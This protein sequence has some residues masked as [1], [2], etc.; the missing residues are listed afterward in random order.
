MA[1]REGK[2]WCATREVCL[3]GHGRHP[4][5]T[6]SSPGNGQGGSRPAPITG[7]AAAPG[8]ASEKRTRG[9]RRGKDGSTR[10]QGLV[11]N[12]GSL[13]RRPRAAPGGPRTNPRGMAS[14]GA[15]GF[16]VPLRSGNDGGGKEP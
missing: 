16:A 5:E 1:A 7:K 10:G 13:P 4:E 3:G 12:K 15:D 8:E 6:P 9:F 11:R 14:V 2:V